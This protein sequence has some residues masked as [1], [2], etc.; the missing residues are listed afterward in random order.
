M[1]LAVLVLFCC[2]SLLTMSIGAGV[3]ITDNGKVTSIVVLR[4]PIF[5]VECSTTTV[6]VTTEDTIK[7]I[8]NV[9]LL[10]LVKVVEEG[11]DEEID[12]AGYDAEDED[13]SGYEITITCDEQLENGDYILTFTLDGVEFSVGFNVNE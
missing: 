4:D 8:A 9:E 5:T 7:G 3:I 6:T 10:K 1:G 13:S 12:I 11:D 2:A